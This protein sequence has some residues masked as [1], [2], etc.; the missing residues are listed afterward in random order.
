M[1]LKLMDVPDG[2]PSTYEGRGW[3]FFENCVA[4]MNREIRCSRL[5][6]SPRKTLCSGYDRNGNYTGYHNERMDG[7]GAGYEGYSSALYTLESTFTWNIAPELHPDMFEVETARLTFGREEDR[8]IVREL[9]Q[10]TFDLIKGGSRA[11][12]Q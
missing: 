4:N 2:F 6:M 5:E 8:I 10:K 7:I 12:L 9:Y 3:P 11:G 1:V